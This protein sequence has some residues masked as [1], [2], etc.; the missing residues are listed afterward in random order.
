[1]HESCPSMCPS[2][3][4]EQL[5]AADDRESQDAQA[6]EEER[7]LDSEEAIGKSDGSRRRGPRSGSQKLLS[8]LQREVGEGIHRLAHTGGRA[9]P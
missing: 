2:A 1:M 7:R 9:M 4:V 5:E 3:D 6:I 8:H